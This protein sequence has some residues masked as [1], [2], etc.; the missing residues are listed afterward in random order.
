MKQLPVRR[1]VCVFVVAVARTMITS[2]DETA[3]N[4]IDP[5]SPAIERKCFYLFKTV[6]LTHIYQNS[7]NGDMHFLCL[8]HRL[9]YCEHKI[10]LDLKI[11]LI[12]IHH[13][14]RIIVRAINKIGCGI[15]LTI[16]WDH[17]T[18]PIRAKCARSF[19]KAPK[20]DG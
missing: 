18:Q 19:N 14:C 15:L 2:T 9:E 11:V 3:L 13:S 16:C 17:V 1:T 12:C 5:H 8:V 6:E 20:A 7:V 10:S 4:L